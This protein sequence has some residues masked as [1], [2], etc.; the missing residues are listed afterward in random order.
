MTRFIRASP[1]ATYRPTVRGHVLRGDAVEH[2]AA[3]QAIRSFGPANRVLRIEFTSPPAAFDLPASAQWVDVDVSTPDRPGAAFSI[4]QAFLAVSAIADAN[5]AAGAANIAGKTV[6]LVFPNGAIVEA[7]ETVNGP[8]PHTGDAVPAAAAALQSAISA[9]ARHQHLRVAEQGSFDIA[10][11]PAVFATLV[12]DDPVAFGH[13]SGE[14]MFALQRAVFDA[15]AAA[16][17]SFIEVR[18]SAG[19]VVDVGGTAPRLQQGVGWSNPALG[20]RSDL[21]GH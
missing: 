14:K 6:R 15:P 5:R 3:L 8:L 21:V 19:G 11:R 10:G 13:A 20:P 17:G 12:T 7:G 4:W 2:A 9:E 1:L 16:A 18:D